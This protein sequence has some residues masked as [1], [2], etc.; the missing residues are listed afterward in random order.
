MA[1]YH[2]KY[3]FVGLG[4]PGPR[5]SRNRHNIG[6][7][8]LN[9]F[10]IDNGYEIEDIKFGK[11][12]D[13][14]SAIFLMPDTYMNNSGSAVRHYLGKIGMNVSNMCVVQDDMD[15]ETGRV[16][17]KFDGGDNGH[18]GVRSINNSIGSREYF[19][20][21]VGIGRPPQ[22]IDPVDYLLSDF[23]L[24]E[25]GSI[26]KAILEASFGVGLILR[27]GF[28]KAMNTINKRRNKSKKEEEIN[29]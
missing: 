22:G 5:Y 17:L 20:L 13:T 1:G 23:S 29:D 14:A 3:L 11:G 27:S 18:N 6:Y 4:N 2:S 12:V 25:L 24:K 7:M 15:L 9:R 26:E 16:I 10:L 28:I 21:R 19:R 8:V